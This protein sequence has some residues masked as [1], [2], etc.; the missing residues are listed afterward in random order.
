MHATKNSRW[1]FPP[2]SSSL[3]PSPSFPFSFS[4]SVS[5]SFSFS[6]IPKTQVR[7]R[8]W[9]ACLF[10]F[11]LPS[12]IR[13]ESYRGNSWLRIALL[14]AFETIV[15][16]EWRN[17]WQQIL[18]VPVAWRVRSLNVALTM[19]LFSN[20]FFSRPR[21]WKSLAIRR[22][23]GAC[24]LRSTKMTTLGYF[25]NWRTKGLKRGIPWRETE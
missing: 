9:F 7:S 6:H 1:P 24:L 8:F 20:L 16:L 25:H 15:F 19:N 5:F 2:F 3:S 13:F 21:W 4:F 14:K 17:R 12:R 11:A 10:H 23:L 18:R 22:L